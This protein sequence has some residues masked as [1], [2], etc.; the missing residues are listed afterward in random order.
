MFLKRVGLGFVKHLWG[1]LDL[2]WVG[3]KDY[4]TSGVGR[5]D[6]VF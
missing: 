5:C 4:W 1:F 2:P 3:R 6:A